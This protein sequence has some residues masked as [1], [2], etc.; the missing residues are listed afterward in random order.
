MSR[1]PT[2]RAKSRAK[3]AAPTTSRPPRSS[4]PRR[5]ERSASVRA[6][7]HELRQN[8]T[9]HSLVPRW[10][11]GLASL[12]GVWLMA[13]PTSADELLVDR[14]VVRFAAPELGGPRSPRFISARV[15]ALEARIEALADP[16]RTG[17]AYRERHVSAAIERHIA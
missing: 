6:R 8:S 7:S 10:L 5:A 1:P 11:L 4:A 14:T 16:D 2:K 9:S 13:R 15:L 17:G 3:R 12:T